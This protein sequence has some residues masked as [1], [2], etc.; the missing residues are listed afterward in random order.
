M[1]NS[2]SVRVFL[3]RVLP[4][5]IQ[6]AIYRRNLEKIDE[7][8][9]QASGATAANGTAFDLNGKSKGQP[10]AVNRLSLNDFLATNSSLD[11]AVEEQPEI[12]IILVPDENAEAALGCLYSILSSRMASYELVIIDNALSGPTGK[13]L[14]RIEG[15]KI[16]GRDEAAQSSINDL[17][18]ERAVGDYLLFLTGKAEI[19][20]GSVDAAL[21]VMKSSADVGAVGG[22]II[23]ADGMLHSAGGFISPNGGPQFYGRGDSPLAPAYMFRRDVDFCSTD[24]LMTARQFFTES[25]PFKEEL[26]FSGGDAGP[27]LCAA[28]WKAGKRVVYEPDV[29]V[30]RRDSTVSTR[31]AVRLR[32]NGLPSAHR[33]TG[34]KRILFIEDSVPHPHLGTG[35][36]RSHRML[37]DMVRMGY[38]VTLYPLV[39]LVEDWESI[40]RDIPREVEVMI[41]YGVARLGGFLREREGYYDLILVS[42]PTNLKALRMAA[43]AE[44][45][46]LEKFRLLYDAEALFCLREITLK[47][48]RGENLSDE[49]VR[50]L[51]DSELE[52]A[53]G[54]ASIMC[55]SEVESRRFTDYGFPQV[56]TLRHAIDCSPTPNPFNSREGLLFVGPVN[57]SGTPNS[58]AV[59]WFA[60]EVFPI[61]QGELTQEIEFLIAG[62]AAAE[63]AA[64]LASES[65]RF[66]G[67][68]DDLT[69][70][71]NHARLFVAPTRFSAGVPLKIYEAA[72]HGLP[73][74]CTSLLASQ[75]AWEPGRE[76]LVADTPTDFAASCLELYRNEELWA[77]LRA[78]A[79]ERVS[80]ECSP[81]KFSGTL[82]RVLAEFLEA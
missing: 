58:D 64:P 44:R 82:R 9:R 74:V 25:G 62:L 35:F 53:R 66:L 72:A 20:A 71:Y 14:E 40:Y 19:L 37:L 81:E 79:L 24:L 69:P 68:V 50:G 56:H 70:I 61:V 11:F 52:M 75:L 2:H 51:I 4:W 54:S 43:K 30:L 26:K 48:L 60:K 10:Q 80:R 47:R 77:N 63:V 23:F 65:V 42:R 18:R 1:I 57:Q 78:N 45:V 7:E 31:R 55:A 29:A 36:P 21:R 8:H 13:L 16:I 22:K 76:L 34:P 73:V 67:K 39:G 33:R 27:A 5:G 6:S 49:Y 17:S 46:S 38:S 3:K 59:T 32:A 41:D 15:A 12:S 28:L